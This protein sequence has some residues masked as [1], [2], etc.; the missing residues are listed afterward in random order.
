[1]IGRLLQL[2]LKQQATSSLETRLEEGTYII[3][4]HHTPKTSQNH[5][6][7][8]KPSSF[9]SRD[10]GHPTRPMCWGGA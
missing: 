4:H 2:E 9:S 5:R 6:F 7:A 3:I 8:D 1:M 10:N